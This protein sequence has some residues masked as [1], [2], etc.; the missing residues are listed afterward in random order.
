MYKIDRLLEDCAKSSQ[1]PRD[2]LSRAW[3][4]ALRSLSSSFAKGRAAEWRGLGSWVPGSRGAQ[5][6]FCPSEH[7]LRSCSA[8]FS[9]AMPSTKPVGPSVPVEGAAEATTKAI[10]EEL[11]RA[12]LAS[13]TTVQLDMRI[14][15]LSSL[16]RAIRFRFNASSTASTLEKERQKELQLAEKAPGACSVANMAD[17]P[18]PGCAMLPQMSSSAGANFERP[19]TPARGGP[20]G[21]YG[22]LAP[23][24]APPEFG[25]YRRSLPTPLLHLDDDDVG[26]D[27]D[28]LRAIQEREEQRRQ[29]IAE[30]VR[31][32]RAD[33]DRQRATVAREQTEE[34][35]KRREER[36]RQ[37]QLDEFNISQMQSKRE[38]SRRPH[39]A[40][41]PGG[42]L[43]R[44]PDGPTE[45]EKLGKVKKA[46]RQQMEETEAQR[47][48]K[49]ID[50]LRNGTVEM[51]KWKSD[52]ENDKRLQ[53][54]SKIM[55]AQQHKAELDGQVK[56]EKDRMPAMA[57]ESREFIEAKRKQNMEMLKI[58]Q[59]M[60]EDRA[61]QK[62]LDVEREHHME[63]ELIKTAQ[64][65]EQARMNEEKKR[66]VLMSQ[67]QKRYFE[68]ELRRRTQSRQKQEEVERLPT[69]TGLE[70]GEKRQKKKRYAHKMTD[71]L[72]GAGAAESE[73]DDIGSLMIGSS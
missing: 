1:I 28:P 58:Q 6:S 64:T 49:K 46:I 50:E 11:G 40:G 24:S 14:G 48:Q 67:Q 8:S 21:P 42:L 60:A 32:E 73:D 51:S 4:T 66:D 52:L 22:A 12:V 15:V 68:E 47:K 5:P 54:T 10:V 63:E 44:R 29:S 2:Q 41:D 13:V 59:A 53:A 30:K 16:G 65:A 37:R 56:E 38:E 71:V 70:V 69:K 9:S 61:R 25:R 17:A 62:K 35:R 55:R 34:E 45:Q 19:R 36:A 43:Y 31:K 27:F 18:G 20:G 26:E 3:E 57:L 33:L 23:A 7:F 39:S 72:V